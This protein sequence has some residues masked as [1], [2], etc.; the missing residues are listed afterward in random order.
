MRDIG[1]VNVQL[2]GEF[3]LR[4]PRRNPDSFQS[5]AEGESRVA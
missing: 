2:E 4:P 5:L 1:R 3:T